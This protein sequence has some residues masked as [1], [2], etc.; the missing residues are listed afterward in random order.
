MTLNA[1]AKFSVAISGLLRYAVALPRRMSVAEGKQGMKTFFWSIALFTVLG[2]FSSSALGQATTGSLSKV[3]DKALAE[4]KE[5]T[6]NPRFARFLGLKAD[7]P[8]PLKRLEFER[9]GITNVLNVL[10]EPPNT[11]ILF[12]R[13]QS[14]ATFYVTDR[15]GILRRAVVNDDAVANGGDKYYAASCCSGI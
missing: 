11:I 5:A 9:E 7:Q 8:V 4:G 1:W 2:L 13:R 6:L 14:L 12:E 3:A 10:R 15:S